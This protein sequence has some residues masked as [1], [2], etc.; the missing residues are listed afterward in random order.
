[1]RV[2]LMLPV[3]PSANRYW[4]RAGTRLYVSEEGVAYR[5]AVA[6]LLRGSRVLAG[7]VAV[8]AVWYRAR[9]AGDVDNRGKVLLDALNGIAWTDDSRIRK[10]PGEIMVPDDGQERC[11]IRIKPYERRHPQPALPTLFGLPP[12]GNGNRMPSFEVRNT[13]LAEKPF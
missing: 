1:M 5:A 8:H 11:V 6:K 4:R 3:P 2:P 9:R 7:D 13:G 12:V 10:D